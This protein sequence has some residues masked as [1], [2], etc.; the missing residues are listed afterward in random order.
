M[1]RRALLRATVSASAVG[2]SEVPRCDQAE[3]DMMTNDRNAPD[4]AGRYYQELA[5]AFVRGRLAIDGART[6]E[7][8]I[9]LGLRRGLRLHKFKRTGGL[10]RVGRVL[11][12]LRGLVPAR[13]LDVGSGRGAALWPTLDAF[14]GLAVL[15]VDRNAQR[16]ADLQAVASGGIDRLSTARMD[17]THLALADRSADVVTI[18]EVLE[19]LPRPDRAAGEVIRVAQRF[20]VA[21][22]PLHADDNPEHIH[23]FNG[24]ALQDLF[25]AA[26]ATRVNI[27]YVRNHII[28]VARV[29]GSS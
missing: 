5:A 17:A 4:L 10:E 15:A 18:L 9:R 13:L 19:H 12:I 7:E 1:V 21:S 14:P 29:G 3:V 20:V 22:V 26:G 2:S 27:E 11:G 6:P 28:A 16:V 24:P 8:W 25:T 23:L